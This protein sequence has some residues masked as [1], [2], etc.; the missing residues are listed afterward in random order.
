MWVVVAFYEVV[1]ELYRCWKILVN[2]HDLSKRK[3]LLRV[4]VSARLGSVFFSLGLGF[5][6][7]ASL[8]SRVRWKLCHL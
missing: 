5:S 2:G 3:S 6:V 1:E 7:F 4:R 8:R